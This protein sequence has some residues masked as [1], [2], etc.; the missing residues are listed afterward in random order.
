MVKTE[1]K[2]TTYEA[3]YVTNTVG[4]ALAK[5]LADLVERRPFDPIE[6]LA[7]YLYKFAENKAYQQKEEELRKEIELIL[8]TEEDDKL[9]R[10]AMKREFEQIKDLEEVE[11]KEKEAHEKRKRELEELAK[12][13]EEVANTQPALPAVREEEEQLVV[14]FGE[15]ELHQLAGS[16]GANLTTPL[17][18][19][20]INLASRNAEFQTA[21][22]VAEKSGLADNVKQI[23]DY[24]C[25]LVTSE[26]YKILDDLLLNGFPNLTK[27]IQDNLGNKEKMEAKGLKGQAEHVYEDIPGFVEKIK[28][29]KL[30]ILKNDTR[31]LNMILDRKQLAFFRDEQG[32]TSI[33]LAIEN[34]NFETAV[35]L[36]EKHPSLVK[37]NDCLGRYA[38]DYFNQI[39]KTNLN[40]AQQQLHEELA[41]HINQD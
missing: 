29:V 19:N 27:I 17:K 14:E 36:L 18:A 11:R 6:Y 30:A 34:L 23:D 20:T 32:R 16:P 10:E 8:K 25:D 15:T 22:D 41:Q 12:R 21:R 2:P 28:N 33:H 31:L 24:I 3:Q 35:H 5:G 13:K 4:P 40:D 9:Q 26:N 39:D 1:I 37:V 38:K 7:N